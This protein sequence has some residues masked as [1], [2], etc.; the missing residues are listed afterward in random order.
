MLT[1]N[2]HSYVRKEYPLWLFILL[3]AITMLLGWGLRGFIGGG[4]F[5]AMIP[6][7]MVMLTICM[8]L[9]IPFAMAAVMVVFGT[10]GIGMGGEMTYGQTL[11]FL[12][13]P[14][15]VWWGTCGSTVKGGV[16]GLVGGTF[17][18]LGLVHRGLNPKT[19][20]TGFLL[21]LIGFVIGLKMINDPKL[22]YF[23]DPIIKP[24]HE[25]WAGLLFGAIALLTWLKIKTNTEVFRLIIHFAG[26]GLIGGALGFGLGAFWLVLGS[27]LGKTVWINEWWKLMEFSFGFIMGGFFG[28][29]A[30]L[31]RKKVKKIF[32]NK[33]TGTFHGSFIRQ[34]IVI[35]MVGFLIYLVIPLIDPFVEGRS[36][37]DGAMLVALRTI[38]RVLNNYTSIGCLLIMIALRWPFVAFQI[39]VTLTFSHT[40]IDLV[41]DLGP[42]HTIVFSYLMRGC[43][44]LLTSIIVS[45]VVAVYQQKQAVLKSI[46][47]ILVW[48]T[49][50][51]ALARMFVLGQ[52]HTATDSS[53]FQFILADMLVFNFFVVAAIVVSLLTVR[54]MYSFKI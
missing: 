42:P 35:L 16:W 23:S 45:Y 29:A 41:E 44:V 7:A 21:F 17:I 2:V 53:I 11:G 49:V 3:P 46:F 31:S 33:M 38:A 28:Y 32:D 39:A 43:I 15:T 52:F 30:W 26:Y 37:A 4:P 22:I 24:R 27:Q 19:I 25:S 9:D 13:N 48:S 18:G 8:L 36:N 6:G 1:G 12:R 51:V 10:A 34:L 54:R 40:M 14:E 20:V 50:A 5:G 47:L